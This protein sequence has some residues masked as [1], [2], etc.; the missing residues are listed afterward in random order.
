MSLIEQFVGAEFFSKSFKI[1]M[2]T[3][4]VADFLGYNKKTVWEIENYPSRFFHFYLRRSKSIQEIVVRL[5][6]Y[7]SIVSYKTITQ[8]PKLEFERIERAVKVRINID[9]FHG[10]IRDIEELTIGNSVKMVH[11]DYYWDVP[12]PKT[13]KE[14]PIRDVDH[15]IIDNVKH[16]SLPERGTASGMVVFEKGKLDCQVLYYDMEPNVK[17]AIFG[18]IDKQVVTIS[19]TIKS[20]L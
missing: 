2:E 5:C 19:H 18:L 13:D 9:H 11:N 16:A 6:Q 8:A 20:K 12:L 4:F 7:A 17:S 15:I 1:Q 10:N 3:I 14:C